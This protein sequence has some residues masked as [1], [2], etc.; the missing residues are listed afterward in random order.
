MKK[1]VSIPGWMEDFLR[2]NP[3]LS[4]SK[5]LQAKIIEIHTFRKRGNTDLNNCQRKLN[6]LSNELIKTQDELAIYKK[7]DIK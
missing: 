1:T 3:D 4:V 7:T 6:F 2:D 5:I